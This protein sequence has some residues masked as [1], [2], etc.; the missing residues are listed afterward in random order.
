MAIYRPP[1]A[2]WPLAVAAFVVGGL[3]GLLG[4]FLL[5]SDPAP[6]EVAA[7]VETELAAAA[8]SLE[9]VAIE[10]EESVVD[11][12]VAKDA[13]YRGARAALDSSRARYDEVAGAVEALAPDRAAAIAAAYE[14]ADAQMHDLVAADELMATLTELEELLRGGSSG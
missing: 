2:R 10:Y 11:G 6:E 7:E 5:R 3:I 4:G 12:A 8:G 1:K 14:D 9:V 13:E